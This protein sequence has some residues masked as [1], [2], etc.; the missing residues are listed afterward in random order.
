ML[1]SFFSR[2]AAIF[3]R[4]LRLLLVPVRG[5]IFAVGLIASV[6][7]ATFSATASVQ[8]TIAPVVAVVALPPLT[9]PVRRELPPGRF[10]DPELMLLEVYR[11]LGANQLQ[12]AQKKADALVT[13]YPNFRLGQLIRGDL[14]MMHTHEVKGM[15]V[16]S[17]GAPDVLRDLR[18][19]ALV[20]LRSLS[21]RPDPTLVP[22][23]ILQLRDDQKFALLVDAKRS[24][25]YVYENVSGRLKFV[26]DYY[27]SQ[28]KLGV[29]KIREGDQK[30]P[31]G[32]YYVT[33]RLAGGRLPE[34]YG[35]GALPIN[36]PNDWDRV[37]GRSG[38]GIWLHGTPPDSF[39]RPPLSSDGCVVLTNQDLNKLLGSIDV[40]KTPVV[41]SEH[42]E[43]VSR[44]KSD[45]ER[46][47]STRV[48]EGWR[49]DAESAD[50]GRISAN[51]STHFKAEHVDSSADWLLK[52][53][54]FL[55]GGAGLT[56]KLRDVT[57]FLYPGKENMLVITFTQEPLGQKI[58]SLLHPLRKRQY[59]T[60]EGARWKII[61]ES[62]L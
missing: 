34:F 2:Q 5:Q 53:P 29:N 7:L 51:Y 40:G 20:R 21:Q 15:G 26:S 25:M 1:R 41:I 13:A 6:I 33:S 58:R 8:A 28:G 56:Y 31:L 32:V 9:I 48:L 19:E 27:I 39:S 55:T 45:S 14:L 49:S 42:I 37:N 47:L 54:E 23:A 4:R 3:S 12:Q 38:S 35:A 52:H 62:L 11:D 16:L 59:W 30:T 22:R 60:L 17:G 18:D 36:Y 46:N 24:R 61:S 44:E 10:P 43:F 50:V 57:A